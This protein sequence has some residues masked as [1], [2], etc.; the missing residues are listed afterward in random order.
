MA[1]FDAPDRTTCTVRRQNTNTPLQ[2]L[3]LMN[4]PQYVEAA[5]LLAER[6]QKS[7]ASD[8]HGQLVYGFRLATGRRPAPEEVV[9][10]AELYEKEEA[11]FASAPADADSLFS[12]GDHPADAALDKT[13]TAALAMVAGL[14][15]NHDE[16]YT[17]R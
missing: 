17:K 12:V 2:A 7:G 10:L 11:R 13:V 4:D 8:L 6:M 14:M 15:I 5:R 1:V 3:V 9:L 16:A